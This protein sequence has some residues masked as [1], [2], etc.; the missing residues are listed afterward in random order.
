MTADVCGTTRAQPWDGQVAMTPECLFSWY[1]SLKGCDRAAPY[2]RVAA[3][4]RQEENMS[5][6]AHEQSARSETGWRALLGAWDA[7]P[8]IGASQAVPLK[9]DAIGSSPR[10]IGPIPNG[11]AAPREGSSGSRMSA[12]L[13]P[14]RLIDQ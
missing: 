13:L 12:R 5:M 7:F 3:P 10:A 4:P 2:G 8:E 1:C 14:L 6:S 9:G 11:N